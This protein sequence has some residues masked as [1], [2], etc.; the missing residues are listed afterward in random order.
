MTSAAGGS[1]TGGGDRCGMYALWNKM[2]MCCGIYVCVC[3]RLP[4]S[5][6]DDAR[7]RQFGTAVFHEPRIDPQTHGIPL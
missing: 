2:C 6:C 5:P 1:G 3:W 4:M 7:R